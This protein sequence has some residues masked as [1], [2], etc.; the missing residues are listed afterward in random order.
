MRGVHEPDVRRN[1]L[2]HAAHRTPLRA[3]GPHPAEATA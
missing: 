2:V 3:G 1:G